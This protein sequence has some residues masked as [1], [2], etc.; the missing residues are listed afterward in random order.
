M[1]Y[2]VSDHGDLLEF[3]EHHNVNPNELEHWV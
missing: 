1:I 2:A 3:T